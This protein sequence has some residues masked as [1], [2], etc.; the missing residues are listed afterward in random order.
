MASGFNE[1]GLLILERKSM[2]GK[3]GHFCSKYQ[4]AIVFFSTRY[5]Y[6][7]NDLSDCTQAVVHIF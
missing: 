5:L 4:S 2:H 7:K 6:V 3:T 1:C